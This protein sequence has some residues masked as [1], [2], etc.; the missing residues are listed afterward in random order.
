MSE[1]STILECYRDNGHLVVVQELTGDLHQISLDRVRVPKGLK[2][3]PMSREEIQAQSA[4]KKQYLDDISCGRV[5]RPTIIVFSSPKEGSYWLG[6][7]YDECKALKGHTS[8][9]V[10]AMIFEHYDAEE[11]ARVMMQGWIDRQ[12]ELEQQTEQSAA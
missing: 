7:H 4:W 11:A 12:E 1:K 8:G 9:V 6:S 5:K 2:T 3:Q 10:N